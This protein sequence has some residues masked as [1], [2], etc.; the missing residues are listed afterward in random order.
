MGEMSPIMLR[1]RKGF[2]LGFYAGYDPD[3]GFNIAITIGVVAFVVDFKKRRM[4]STP[5]FEY[6]NEWKR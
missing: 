1:I 6:V 4:E 2:A 3:F 5:L